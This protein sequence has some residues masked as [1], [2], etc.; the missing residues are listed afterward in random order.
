[1][2][3]LPSLLIL[4]GFTFLGELLHLLL[5]LPIPAAIYGLALLFL[6][7]LTGLVKLEAIQTVS[8]FMINIMP[9]LFVA[10]SVNLL[11]SWQALA[12]N[13][14]PI[15]IIVAA[16]TVLV[17]AVTGRLTQWLIEKEEKKNG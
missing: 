3:H 2:K 6:A 1:M 5:P 8:D 14:V 10:P 7:L 12:A 16:S 4:L 17:F 9:V 13:L 11:D 15:L